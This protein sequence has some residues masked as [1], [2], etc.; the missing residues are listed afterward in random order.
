MARST[1]ALPLTGKRRRIDRRWRFLLC[2]CPAMVASTSPT[3]T[4]ALA[5]PPLDAVMGPASEA[6]N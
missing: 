2:Q 3:V 6:R 5:A 4:D 1:Q